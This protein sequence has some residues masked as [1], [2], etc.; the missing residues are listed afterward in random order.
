MKK[1]FII[2]VFVFASLAG[3]PQVFAT[4][5][6]S[7]S[8][9]AG[10]YP[11]PATVL[12]TTSDG[13]LNVYFAHG[14]APIAATNGG[15][16][17]V[18]AQNLSTYSWDAGS[19]PGTVDGAYQVVV[20]DLASCQS[21]TPKSYSACIA[22]NSGAHNAEADFTIGSTPPATTTL[23]TSTPDQAEQNLYN[24]CVLFFIAFFG[25]VWL[26]RKH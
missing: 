12:V 1:L 8:T 17:G 22:A 11:N 25:T 9:D 19:F 10:S 18:T 20:V 14:S 23:A 7:I 21:P 13:Q 3:A 2:G 6:C 16:S 15:A 4:S 26:M 5:C 24:A